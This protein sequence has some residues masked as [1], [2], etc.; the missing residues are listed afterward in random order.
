MLAYCVVGNIETPIC[1]HGF[2]VGCYQKWAQ[3]QTCAA[4]DSLRLCH[5]FNHFIHLLVIRRVSLNIESEA[6]LGTV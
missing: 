6:K 5:P 4:D 2:A 1:F 3:R